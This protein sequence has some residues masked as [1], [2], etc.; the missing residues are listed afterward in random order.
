M[1]LPE[2]MNAFVLT[3]HGGPEALEFHENW[4]VPMPGPNDVLIKVGACGLN[5]TDVNTRAGWY[6]KAVSGATTDDGHEA[7]GDEDPSWGGAPLQFPRI[8]GADAVGEV[9]AVG[10]AAPA[11]L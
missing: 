1:T 8:Q 3:R 5:N 9:V 6:S 4:P 11:E 2:T 10:D 7:V